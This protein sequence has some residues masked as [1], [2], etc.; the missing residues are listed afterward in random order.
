MM[1]TETRIRPA[2]TGCRPQD[3]VADIGLLGV[4][5]RHARQSF[6]AF[7]L[8]HGNISQFV[9]TQHLGG[10]LAPIGQQDDDL[11]GV[12]DNMVVGD[13]DAGRIDDEPGPGAGDL[14]P[15]D[16]ETTG[17]ASPA[18]YRASEVMR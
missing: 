2:R 13:D 7:H 5:P 6:L 14:L 17:L 18:A 15:L 9:A 12:I 10:Q 3:P 8:D 1:P 4:A 11:V 16:C